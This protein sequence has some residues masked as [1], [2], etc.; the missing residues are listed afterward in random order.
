MASDWKKP[1][2]LT[3]IEENQ[4]E[5]FLKDLP[6]RKLPGVGQKA[7]EI[8]SG[9]GITRAADLRKLSESVLVR[10]FGKFGSRLMELASGIDPSPVVPDSEPKSISAEDTLEENTEDR[11]VFRKYLLAQAEAVGRRL[12]KNSLQGRTITLKLKY[13]DFHLITRSRTIDSPT[14]ST[15][16]IIGV[17]LELL[18]KERIGSKVRLIG[19]GVS[20]FEEKAQQLALFEKSASLDEKQTRLDRAMDQV[21]ERFGDDA[22][23]R[24]S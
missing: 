11:D 16:T 1:D 14:D 22:L 5:T 2:G 4:V 21:S 6:V 13:S 7:A 17:A 10:K 18:E 12:R 15:K 19:V 24:G 20:N 23:K 3:L 9:L 8:C